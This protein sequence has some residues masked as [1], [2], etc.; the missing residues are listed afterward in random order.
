MGSSHRRVTSHLALEVAL[1][2]FADDLGQ[3]AVRLLLL[4]LLL[5]FGVA[6]HHLD[7]RGLKLRQSPDAARATF[8]S[9]RRRDQRKR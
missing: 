1:H 6:D 4:V 3:D 7:H 5:V 9:I 8:L 2:P